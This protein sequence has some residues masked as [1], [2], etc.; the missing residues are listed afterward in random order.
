MATLTEL[1]SLFADGDLI[2]KISAALVISVKDLLDGA[3]PTAA[4]RAYAAKVF[5]GPHKEAHRALM[6]VLAANAT[7]SVEQ[8]QGASDSAIQA[9][10]DAVVPVLRDVDAGV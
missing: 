2:K 6:F 3:T 5:A 7:A 4:D 10:V 8:I 9:N 1:T